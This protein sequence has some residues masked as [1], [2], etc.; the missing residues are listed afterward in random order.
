VRDTALALAGRR[1]LWDGGDV[2]PMAPAEEPL[3]PRGS[4]KQIALALRRRAIGLEAAVREAEKQSAEE[5]L[6]IA[7]FYSTGLFS[8]GRLRELKHPYRKGASPPADPAM[9]NYHAGR[10]YRGWKVRPPRKSGGGLVTKLVNDSPMA[11]FLLEGT[12][13]MIARPILARIRER[14]K[15][16]R[17]KFLTAALKKSRG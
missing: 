10:F 5:A 9:I 4:P 7:R 15:G 17:Q 12:R 2:V 1:R 3:M 14:L 16:K 11:R 13:F 6:K 8:L